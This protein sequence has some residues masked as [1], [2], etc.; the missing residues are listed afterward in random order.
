MYGTTQNLQNLSQPS[1]IVKKEDIFLEEFLI[2]FILLFFQIKDLLNKMLL[3][4]FNSTLKD[5]R[6]VSVNSVSGDFN[7]IVDWF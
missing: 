6:S 2:L 5:D 3:A 1:W 4:Y 7:I